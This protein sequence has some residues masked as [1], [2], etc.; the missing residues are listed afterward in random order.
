MQRPE[1]IIVT[2]ALRE[3]N[4]GNWQTA[5]RWA[6]WLA[7][8]FRVQVVGEWQGEPADA[9]IALHARRSARSIAA[10]ADAHPQAPLVVVLTGT[11]LYRDIHIDAEARR[12]LTWAQRLVVLHELA[13]LDVPTPYRDK[14]RVCFQSCRSRR[15]LD[16]SPRLLRALMVGHLRD[17]KQ[18]QTFWGAAESLSDRPDILFDHVGDALDDALGLAARDCQQRLPQY[19]WLGGQ[20][21]GRTRER[22]QRAHVL[23]HPSRMEGGAHVVMEA[24]TSGTPVL[25]SRIPGNVGL[26]GP[27]YAGYFPV[28]DTDALATLLSQCRDDPD[29]LDD[30]IGQCAVRAPLFAPEREAATLRELMAE[31]MAE[32]AAEA[33]IARIMSGAGRPT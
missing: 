27:D 23:V 25:A 5:S 16:K 30:L 28:G 6:R 29:F 12:S 3:A 9:M 22:I 11:D 31:A 15:A 4:N 19:R 24:I 13:P 2:P 14:C 10:W 18:P 20:S 17:E 1:L 33:V 8:D 32:R 7:A 21:H 26:L